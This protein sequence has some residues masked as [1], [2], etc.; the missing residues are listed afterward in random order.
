ML[1]IDNQEQICKTCD[2]FYKFVT[3]K[4]QTYFTKK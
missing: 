2:K 3:K 1:R 4:M